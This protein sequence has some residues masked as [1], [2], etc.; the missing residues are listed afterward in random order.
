VSSNA[1]P[2]PGILGLNSPP[3]QLSSRQAARRLAEAPPVWSKRPVQPRR[4]LL[5]ALLL[6]GVARLPALLLGM[7]HYGDGPVRVEIAER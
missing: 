7:E 1:G 6:A 2:A 3:G 4:L 5:A